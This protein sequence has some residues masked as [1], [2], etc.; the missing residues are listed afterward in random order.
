MKII[1]SSIILFTSRKRGTFGVTDIR[2]LLKLGKLEEII[3]VKFNSR[4]IIGLRYVDDVFAIFEKD[5]DETRILNKLNT[6]VR[7]IKFTLEVEKN[8]ECLHS[9][10]EHLIAFRHLHKFES[11]SISIHIH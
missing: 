1:S 2:H 3:K 4:I 8:L 5:I 11:A 7:N 10:F 9:T 6:I